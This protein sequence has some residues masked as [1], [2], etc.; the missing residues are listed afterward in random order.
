MKEVVIGSFYTLRVT[1]SCNSILRKNHLINGIGGSLGCNTERVVLLQQKIRNAVDHF[2]AVIHYRVHSVVSLRE[3]L[4][5]L[6][7]KEAVNGLCEKMG[8]SVDSVSGLYWMLMI[9]FGK[10]RMERMYLRTRR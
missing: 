3:D 5:L 9:R 7:G 2:S 1:Y 8:F 6:I 10:I 4:N